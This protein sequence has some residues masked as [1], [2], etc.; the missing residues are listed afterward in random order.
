MYD[1]NDRTIIDVSWNESPMGKWTKKQTIPD[2]KYIIGVKA[3][4]SEDS[5]ITSLAFV[6]APKSE[7]HVE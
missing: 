1:D 4:T 7:M 6:L 2:D 3:D 5:Y